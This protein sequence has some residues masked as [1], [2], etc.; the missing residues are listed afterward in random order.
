VAVLA[1]TPAGAGAGPV[2][3][4]GAGG[5]TGGVAFLEPPQVRWWSCLRRCGPE[6]E[7]LPGGLLRLRGRAL[8]AVTRVIYHGEAGSADDV[9]VRVRP[10]GPRRLTV[11]VHAE[12][13]SGPVTAVVSRRLRSPLGPRV[14]I[15]EAE[16]QPEAGEVQVMAAPLR[17]VPGSTDPAAPRLETGLDRVRAFY[18]ER[19]GVTFSYRVSAPEPVSVQVDLV[20]PADGAVVQSWPPLSVPLA[21]RQ[22]VSWRGTAVG[23]VAPEGRYA[24]RV[25][26]RGSGGGQAQ[27]AQATEPRDAFDFHDH[28]FPVRGRHD[29]GGS[30]ARFG[31]GRSGRSHQGQDLFAPCGTRLAAA[32]GGVVQF[33]QYH[34]AAGHYL[35][36]D[37]DN[38]DQDYVYMHLHDAPPVRRG[39]RVYTG[40]PIGAV[41]A[42]GNAHGC[43][44][45]FELWSAPGWYD[46]GRP[47]DPLPALQAWDAAS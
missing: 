16:R 2:A 27:S 10:R 14:E 25:T 5:D 9:S 22:S 6:G 47:L 30:G 13:V 1:G 29:F 18:G 38:T 41:G 32:R 15:G 36:I 11:R 31:T 43:H 42:S 8:G 20:R 46:G 24:F 28:L 3:E 37:G 35:V 26:A 12:A 19:N 34:A 7:G 23:A 44:L 4:R 17:P 21:E 40:Q 45:H 39:Q 33:V